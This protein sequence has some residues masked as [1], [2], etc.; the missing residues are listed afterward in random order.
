MLGPLLKLRH[1]LQ[2]G[3]ESWID[4]YEFLLEPQGATGELTDQCW[5]IVEVHIRRPLAW[6]CSLLDMLGPEL[7]NGPLQTWVNLPQ[8]SNDPN[9]R[10]IDV[11]EMN[12]GR[13]AHLLEKQPHRCG[14][15]P[16]NMND[17]PAVW[18]IQVLIRSK[19]LNEQH[20]ADSAGEHGPIE[21]GSLSDHG[22]R[23]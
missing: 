13:V 15:P 2:R 18:R 7:W 1:S 20:C 11:P 19:I 17:E 10:R 6:Q 4:G 3:S 21:Q 16:W 22:E 23:S 14:I 8:V 9:A 12:N 5:R